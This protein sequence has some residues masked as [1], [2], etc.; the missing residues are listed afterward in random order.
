MKNLVE[1]IAKAIVDDPK[2][3]SVKE[4]S[5]DSSSII[6]LKCAKEDLGKLIGK[7]GNTAQSIRSVIFAASFKFKKRYTLDISANN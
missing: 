6:E 4:L 2:Q 1:T 5:G 7:H 3:I